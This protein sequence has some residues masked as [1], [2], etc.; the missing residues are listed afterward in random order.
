[1]ANGLPRGYTPSEYHEMSWRIRLEPE[2]GHLFLE[3]FSGSSLRRLIRLHSH[4]MSPTEARELAQAL[5]RESGD[6]DRTVDQ[7]EDTE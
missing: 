2:T 4:P 6:M 7:E 1:M 3:F 5:L